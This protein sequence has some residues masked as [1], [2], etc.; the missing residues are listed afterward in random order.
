MSETL[1]SKA[2]Y[3]SERE[4]AKSTMVTDTAFLSKLNSL[5]PAVI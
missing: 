5:D 2:G 3:Y 1:L 4:K